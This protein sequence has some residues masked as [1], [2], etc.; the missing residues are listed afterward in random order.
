[1]L[2]ALRDGRL[3]VGEHTLFEPDVWLTISDEG[4]IRIGSGSFLNIA[5][6]VAAQSS[7]RSAIT[8]CSPTAAS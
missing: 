2:E 4:R 7:S 1:M 8:A 3:E 6:M 5:V